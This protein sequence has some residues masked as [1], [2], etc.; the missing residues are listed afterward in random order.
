[1]M[2][3]EGLRIGYDARPIVS[4]WTGMRTYAVNLLRELVQLKPKA[5]FRL[6]F[7]I[8][9]PDTTLLLC[10]NLYWKQVR[11][12]SGWWWT[13]FQMPATL[14]LDKIDLFHAE[15]IVPPLSTCPS[16]VT[17]HDAISAMFL[18]PSGLKARIVTNLLSFISL[19]KARFVLV[20]SESAK[21]DVARLFKVPLWKIFVTPYGVSESFR[22]LPKE[23]AKGKVYERFG[24]NGRF[25]LTVNFFRP[26]KNAPL[27]A[28]AFRQLH[29]RFVPVDW[30]VLVG[31]TTEGLKKQ[32]LQAAGEA[33]DR[34]VFTGY[35]NDDDLPFLYSAS[36]VFAFPSCYEGFGLPVLEAMACGS[37]VVAGDA[38]A[39]NEFARPAAI[40][41][42]PKDW[43]SLAEALE[44]VLVNENLAESLRQ[45]GLKLASDFTWS[46]T[47]S[48]T[49]QVYQKAISNP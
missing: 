11:A 27:L 45:K 2:E 15:Y 8:G 20:P 37:P 25:I 41:V 46:R 7:H 24:I 18:E 22:P 42:P 40:L 47:A 5:N 12:I 23:I 19:Q 10:P 30:L 35:V 36:D 29:R 1:M 4:R 32:I 16:I 14:R 28:A 39:V 44:Q 38:P 9:E 49:W 13:M 48:L 6:Y 31:A 26:R 43:K 33:S 17:M 34:I 21:R 3:N